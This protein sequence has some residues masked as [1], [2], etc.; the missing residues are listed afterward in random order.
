[1]PEWKFIAAI[2]GLTA[3]RAADAGDMTIVPES[4]PRVSEGSLEE[5]AHVKRYLAEF[6]GL[7]GCPVPS[8]LLLRRANLKGRVPGEDLVFLRNTFA[9]SV[10]L[11]SRARR[12]RRYNVSIPQF[13]DAFEWP[14]TWLVSEPR[15]IRVETAATMVLGDFKTFCG[16]PSHVYPYGTIE[17]L[18]WDVPL[19]TALT[20]LWRS[21]RTAER[22]FRRKIA[23]AVEIAYIAHRAPDNPVK[24]DWYYGVS[25]ALL[26]TA[27]ETIT[28]VSG[29]VKFEDVRRVVEAVPWPKELRRKLAHYDSRS[30]HLLSHRPARL[31]A[32]KPPMTR[33]VQVCSRLY[34]TRNLVFHGEPIRGPYLRDRRRHRSW[35]HLPYEGAA[36]F[37]CVLLQA[38]ASHGHGSYAVPLSEREER[39]L[40]TGLD[41]TDRLIRRLTASR[42]IEEAH[43]EYYSALWEARSRSARRR[44]E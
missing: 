27:L 8:L 21:R 40:D 9:L 10:T 11:L 20:S 4:D 29:A 19:F 18:E 36:L 35:G 7:T 30:P 32:P 34:R 44:K 37:R 5:Y 38:L 25:N 22:A 1:M 41:M 17:P 42:A 15:F 6:R 24:N 31:T 28:N 2:P 16:H 12:S 23:R 43:G 14:P 26:V 39:T 3:Q 13:T 33:P